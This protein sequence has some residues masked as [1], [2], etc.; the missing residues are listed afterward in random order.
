M[1]KCFRFR[2]LKGQK[3][4]DAQSGGTAKL[5]TVI[6]NAGKVA[7]IKCHSPE[8]E[9]LYRTILVRCACTEDVCAFEL[10]FAGLRDYYDSVPCS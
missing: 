5:E 9:G 4:P 8:N 10:R 6:K 1:A 7:G 2:F 3:I